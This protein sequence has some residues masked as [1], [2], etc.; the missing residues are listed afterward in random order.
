M[1]LPDAVDHD[2]RR[3]RILRIGQPIRQRR[4]AAGGIQSFRRDDL[5]RDSDPE[6]V[7]NPG[8]HFVERRIPN[9]LRKNER[10]AARCGSRRSSL[11][12]PADRRAS[13]Y[14]TCASSFL[15]LGVALFRVA[16][17]RSLQ[18]RVGGQAAGAAIAPSAIASACV[19]PAGVKTASCAS[20][21]NMPMSSFVA[22]CE[23][24]PEFRPS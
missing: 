3:Q 15:Q 6:C 18:F 17:Q 14:R 22:Q 4:S 8:L 7:R 19:V 12:R 13:S 21:G 10:A 16:F 23:P 11:R 9:A 24:E 5:W 2:A 1:I 20:L